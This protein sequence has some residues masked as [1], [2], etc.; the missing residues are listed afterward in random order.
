MQSIAH[1]IGECD[2]GSWRLRLTSREEKD[3]GRRSARFRAQGPGAI[4]SRHNGT[5]FGPGS[6]Y[7]RVK[8][9]CPEWIRSVERRVSCGMWLLH[10]TGATDARRRSYA[11]PRGCFL[12]S[13]PERRRFVG[14]LS[15]PYPRLRTLPPAT[16]RPHAA[17]RSVI[18]RANWSRIRVNVSWASCRCSEVQR[19]HRS[20]WFIW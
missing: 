13:L 4:L 20:V 18:S 6:D 11:R 3:P 8:R 5:I 1:S 19:R 17:S 9:R 12:R 15:D 14:R 10:A 16:A 7:V 2:E